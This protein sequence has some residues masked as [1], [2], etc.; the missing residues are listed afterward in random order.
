MQSKG[1]CLCGRRNRQ[2]CRTAEGLKHAEEEHK[3]RMEAIKKQHALHMAD[4]A[5]RKEANAE[6]LKK[7]KAAYDKQSLSME[8]AIN[9]SQRNR[10]STSTPLH[11]QQTSTTSKANPNP[12]TPTRYLCHRR[13][14]EQSRSMPKMLLNP[15][16]AG[17]SQDQAAAITTFLLEH[18]NALAAAKANGD[19]CKW[20]CGTSHSAS[21]RRRRRKR[22]ERGAP[23][24]RQSCGRTEW[25]HACHNQWR[26][27]WQQD[28]KNQE[29]KGRT[30]PQPQVSNANT[31]RRVLLLPLLLLLATLCAL[32]GIGHCDSAEQ[33]LADRCRAF[34]TTRLASGAPHRTARAPSLAPCGT[35]AASSPNILLQFFEL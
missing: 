30:Q 12:A 9:K 25:R 28:R 19:T 18:L 26:H 32:F 24:G 2:G 4:A 21:R 13:P 34:R 15:L 14:S 35:R 7:Y 5:K 27:Q 29:R 20:G 22:K 16:L 31:V 8:Q 6:K 10:G 23:G 33:I 3:A 11:Q 17:I 1:S